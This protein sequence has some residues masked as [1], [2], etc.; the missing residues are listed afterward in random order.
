MKKIISNI[1]F[2]ENRP[3]RLGA[4][5][6]RLNKH[7]VVNDGSCDET[8]EIAGAMPNAVVHTHLQNQGYGANQR[9]CYKL[10]GAT[11]FVFS[12]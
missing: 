10:V 7:I 3:L 9:I 4:Y 8:I 11:R 12:L 6:E 2:T 5:I 1:V